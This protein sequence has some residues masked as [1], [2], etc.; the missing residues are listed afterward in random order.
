L[1]IL[2]IFCKVND[3][4]FDNAIYLGKNQYSPLIFLNYAFLY[5]LYGTLFC[6]IPVEMSLSIDEARCIYASFYNH[7][8]CSTI[9][10]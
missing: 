3:F 2:L 6:E 10:G 9:E 5:P 4:I 7:D 8:D 1:L